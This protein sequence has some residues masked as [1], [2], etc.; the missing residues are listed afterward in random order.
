[1]EKLRIGVFG[2]GHLGSIHLK[3]IHNLPDMYD[4]AGFYDPVAEV[5]TRV[6][7]E[8][9]AKAYTDPHELIANVDVVDVVAPTTE[10]YR[11]VKQALEAGKH[12]FVE[13]PVTESAD[14]AEQLLDLSLRA[15]RK[16]QIGHVERFNPA[17]VAIQKYN[18]RPMFI[19][20]HRL[21]QFNPRGTDVS[22]VHDLMIHDIDILVSLIPHEIS[23]V[24][25]SGVGVVSDT[26]DI[27]NARVEFENG[28]V[29]NLTASRISLKNMRKIRLFQ[30]DTYMSVDFLEKK[31]EIV[32]LYD[33]QPGGDNT[34]FEVELQGRSRWLVADFPDVVSH[35]AIE[36]ELKSFYS[37]IA[38]DRTPAVSLGDALRSMRM[39]QMILEAIDASKKK[40]RL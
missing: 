24:H 21:A 2:A 29:A 26:P 40:A 11:L 32:K 19:E 7:G 14:Q 27:C 35:N 4:L 9:E 25:A 16:V 17:F 36:E 28:A 39:A 13:K 6:S 23:E 33:E 34:A 22:V 37:A 18:P 31:A 5:R 12:V 20:G 38:E 8:F 1:M 3:C 10:H 30:P 15:G